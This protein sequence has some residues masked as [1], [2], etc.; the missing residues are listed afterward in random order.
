MTE[1]GG[2]RRLSDAGYRVGAPAAF[3]ALPQREPLRPRIRCSETFA[4][5]AEAIAMVQGKMEPAI[6]DREGTV[7]GQTKDG[8]SFSYKYSYA[9]LAQICDVSRALL[10]EQK[11]ATFQAPVVAESGVSV[12]TLLVH[13]SGEWI[14]CV[15]A[16]PLDKRTPQ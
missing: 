6:K 3:D 7:Q 13:A 11:V 14:E 1:E 8:K 10:G 9:N 16:L 4:K 2:I 12:T 5:L 15:V